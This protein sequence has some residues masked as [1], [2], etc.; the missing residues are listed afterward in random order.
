MPAKVSFFPVDNGDMCL[1]TL[2]G[3]RTLLIDINI[4]ASAD[5]PGD[6]TRDVAKDLKERLSKDAD[7]RYYVDVFVLSHPDQDHCAGL[8][9]HFHLGPPSESTGDKIII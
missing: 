3:G 1:I 7:G 8:K 6:T 9:K 2:P 4:R 5:D